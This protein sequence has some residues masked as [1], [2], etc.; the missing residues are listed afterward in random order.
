[1]KTLYRWCASIL[2]LCM[3]MTGAGCAQGKK[4]E[5]YK[6]HLYFINAKEMSLEK[7]RYTLEGTEA[8]EE[9]NEMMEQLLHVPDGAKYYSA[10]PEGVKVNEIKLQGKILKLDFSKKYQKMSASQE[11]LMKEALV[12][13]FTQINGIDGVEFWVDGK[14]LQKKNGS[15]QGIMYADDFV[16]SSGAD[17][18]TYQQKELVLYFGDSSGK[19]LVK[20]KVNVRYNS[21]MSLEKLILERLIKGPSGKSEKKVLPSEMRILG[22]SVKDGICYVNLDQT[23]LD[24]VYEVEPAVTIYSIVNSIIDN[25]TAAQVQISVNGQTNEKFQGSISLEKPLARNENIMEEEEK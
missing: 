1:M 6:N 11:V 3:A 19:K 8:V 7:V 9:A 13:S 15:T 23:F 14:P 18:H 16:Q 5:D 20:E 21:N 17:I 2:I 10:V 22:V 4:V 25:G 24:S 12:L